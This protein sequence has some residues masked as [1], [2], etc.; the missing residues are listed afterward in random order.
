[1]YL[2][3]SFARDDLFPVVVDIATTQS[4]VKHGMAASTTGIV[5]DGVIAV[6]LSPT[7]TVPVGTASTT[8]HPPIGRTRSGATRSSSTARPQVADREDLAEVLRRRALTEDA[9][10][11]EAVGTPPR[12]RRAHRAGEP[13]GPRRPR[14]L[15]RVRALRDRRPARQAR[16]RGPDRADPGRRLRR[17]HGERQRR[18]LRRGAVRLRGPLLRLH[19]ARR[20]P[21]RARPPQEG[22]PLRA[23]RAHAPAGRPL[24][25]G[26]GRAAGR[27]R[28]PGRLGARRPRLRALGEALGTGAADR[29]RRRPLLRRQRGARRLLGPDRRHRER[30]ARHGRAGDDRGRRPR[31]GRRRR[32]RAARDAG[33]QRRDRR[34]RRRR[35]RGDGGGQEAARLLPGRRPRPGAEPD[36]A[37]SARDGARAPAPRLRRRAD[38]RDARRRGLGHLP[39]RALRAGDGHRPGP[40]RGPAAGRDRQRHPPHGRGDHQRRRRQGGPLPAALRRLRAAGRLPGR[41]AGDDGRAGRPRRPA[42]SATPRACCSPAPPC[43]CR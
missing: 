27:H 1:M 31:Q 4:A 14:L 26:R 39:A 38:R 10:R 28:L 5:P 23:D 29:R 17:R 8:S 11:P 33:G 40:D 43:G 35:G 2:L 3:S 18:A 19:G 15:R 13:R 32:D 25:R 6:R 16:G 12:G 7:L 37:R 41:H 36:Q 20:H 42:S 21:G 24:R 34:R 30:L 9:A 22:P